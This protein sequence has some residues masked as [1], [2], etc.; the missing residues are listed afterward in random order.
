MVSITEI[1]GVVGGIAGLLSLALI[2]YKTIR[3]KPIISCEIS[4]EPYYYN[5]SNESDNFIS[6]SVNAKIH[7]RG[8][9]H[10]TIHDWDLAFEYNNEKFKINNNNYGNPFQVNAD[11]TRSQYFIL[12]IKK[13]KGPFKDYVK[14]CALTMYHTF[15]EI[16]VPCEKIKESK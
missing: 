16:T 10:T 8:S 13:E 1:V 7:N 4:G 11:S 2:I 3:E 5:P 9:R 15:G 6:F 12:N 14:N